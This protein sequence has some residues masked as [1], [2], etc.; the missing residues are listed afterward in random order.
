[1]LRLQPWVYIY[2]GAYGL[3]HVLGAL[4]SRVVFVL[5]G[6][7][8]GTQVQTADR[9]RTRDAHDSGGGR[10][11]RAG[12]GWQQRAAHAERRVSGSHEGEWKEGFHGLL[13]TETE[14]G[15]PTDRTRAA[16]PEVEAGRRRRFFHGKGYLVVIMKSMRE[17]VHERMQTTHQGKEQRGKRK[18]QTTTNATK[19]E[20]YASRPPSEATS[21]P[22]FE[23][24]E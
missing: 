7:A 15:P 2:L 19:E 23:K 13:V 1:M 22:V 11:E 16:S 5:L 14:H 8:R 24:Q 20:V 21:G 10:T 4:A 9:S 12:G 3:R 6:V 17:H 18:A